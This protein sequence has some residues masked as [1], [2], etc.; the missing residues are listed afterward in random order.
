M[1]A[2]RS[3]VRVR[4]MGPLD[5]T[6]YDCDRLRCNLCG[7]VFTAKPPPGVGEE[8]YDETAAA[9]IALMKYGCG[10]PFNRLERLGENLGIPL[11]AA[12][13][14]EVVSAAA[15]AFHPVWDELIRQ[16]ATGEVVH[17]DDTN[18]KV[19]SIAKEIAAELAAGQGDRTGIFTSGVVSKVADHQIA[20]F[21]TG[22]DHAGENLAKVLAQRPGELPPP[23]QMCDALSRNTSPGDFETILGNCLTHGRRQF[24]DVA[25]SFPD[26]VK[27]V[28][29]TLREVY[30]HDATA[31][32][33]GMS[34]KERLAHHRKH[35]GPLMRDLKVWLDA[36]I[37]EKKVEPASS[38]GGAIQYIDNHWDALTLFLRVPGAPLDNNLCER[39]LKRAIM[40][41]KNSLFYKT[42]NGARVG[43]MFLSLIHTA[44]LCGANPFEY[45]V[46]VQRHRVAVAANPEQ[47]MPWT[48]V[49]TLER[50]RGASAA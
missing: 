24:V 41:R 14:W 8:K 30:R 10:L 46:A 49:V 42:K 21:F 43:D 12:T 32:K 37:T 18:M 44:E 26:E 31:R 48:Y 6:V 25:G 2:P 20:V 22:R 50:L 19:L 5:A 15:E 38:L 7:E 13:Q 1:T 3:L 17:I 34:A 35:S 4:G 47:W 27:H 23:I 40:H 39:A 9:M 16:A 11:P 29:E 28:L 45:L 36:L 33:E